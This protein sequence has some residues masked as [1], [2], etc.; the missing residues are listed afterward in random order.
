MWKNPECVIIVGLR[1]WVGLYK[2]KKI[3]LWGWGG[4]GWTIGLPDL[5]SKNIGCVWSSLVYLV[6]QI[7]GKQYTHMVDWH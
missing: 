3:L 5:A 2:C 1:T 6:L 7:T 4:S